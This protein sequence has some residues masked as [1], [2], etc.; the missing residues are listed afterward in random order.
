MVFL[1]GWDDIMAVLDLLNSRLQAEVCMCVCAWPLPQLHSSLFL[2]LQSH[3]YTLLP[4]HSMLS[5]DDQQRV[6]RV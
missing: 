2:S 3:R 1:P 4:L 6:F 5:S